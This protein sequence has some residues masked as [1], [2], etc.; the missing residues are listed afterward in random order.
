M[1]GDVGIVKDIVEVGFVII[2]GVN[3][4]EGYFVFVM[5]VKCVYK[6]YD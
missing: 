4:I 5:C 6:L 2:V 3:L 1:G